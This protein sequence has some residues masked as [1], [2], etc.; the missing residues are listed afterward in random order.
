MLA[1]SELKTIRDFA[2]SGGWTA[3]STLVTVLVVAVVLIA[4]VL[5]L[6]GRKRAEERRNRIIEDPALAQKL[7]TN[8]D[9]PADLPAPTAGLQPTHSESA[10]SAMPP[11]ANPQHGNPVLGEPRSQNPDKPHDS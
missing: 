3:Q 1:A 6:R 2:D 9:S 10:N 7:R 5:L 8:E 4:A 11:E